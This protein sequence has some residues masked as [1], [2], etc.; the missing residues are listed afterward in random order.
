MLLS[1]VKIWPAGIQLLGRMF[2]EPTMIKASF[3]YEQATK[4]RKSPEFK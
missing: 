2:D 4:H 3:A 1:N